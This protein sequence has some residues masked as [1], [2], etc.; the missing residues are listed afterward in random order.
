MGGDDEAVHPSVVV[1]VAGGE[2]RFTIYP[3]ADHDSWTETYRNPEFYEW[4]FSQK[5][6]S[7]K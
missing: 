5:R 2:V 6:N 1:V 3:E 7:E 4:L